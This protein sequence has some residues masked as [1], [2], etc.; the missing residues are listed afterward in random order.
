MLDQGVPDER[1]L[2]YATGNPRFG[3]VDSYT[4]VASRFLLE[5]EH[6]FSVYKDLERKRTKPLD[7]KVR[8]A[9][10]ECIRASY[11]RYMESNAS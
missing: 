1:V 3:D 11:Q 9:A 5:V 8:D 10:Q 2:A 7:W 4:Q 6:F